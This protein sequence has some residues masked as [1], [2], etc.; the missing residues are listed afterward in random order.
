MFNQPTEEDDKIGKRNKI[1][2]VISNFLRSNRVDPKD[3][4]LLINTQETR[5][6]LKEHDD[7]TVI[8]ADKG[9]TTVAMKTADD[10]K[11]QKF[12]IG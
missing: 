4:I 10:L 1:V 2:N 12:I 7:I 11:K 9:N 6:F 5:I 8:K 3:I